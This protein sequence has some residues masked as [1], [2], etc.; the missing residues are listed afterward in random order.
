MPTTG[1]RCARR[2]G[3]HAGSG[4]RR[5]RAGRC[6][7]WEATGVRGWGRGAAYRFGR[8]AD[9]ARVSTVPSS[10]SVPQATAA[11]LAALEEDVVEEEAPEDSEDEEFLLGG[12]DEDEDEPG[13][14]ATSRRERDEAR[15]RK[16]RAAR[17][18]ESA[19]PFGDWLYEAMEAEEPVAGGWV[20]DTSA[21]PATVEE[22]AADASLSARGGRGRGRGSGRASDGGA[23]GA[24]GASS[25]SGG[26]SGGIADRS[27]AAHDAQRLGSPPGGMLQS[28]APGGLPPLPTSGRTRR[29]RRAEGSLR[30]LS[31][32]ELDEML[33]SGGSGLAGRKRGGGA[34]RERAAAAAAAPPPPCRCA[35]YLSSRAPPQRTRAPHRACSVCGG[36]GRYACPRCGSRSCSVRCTNIHLETWCL[37]MIA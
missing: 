30:E 22:P 16:S 34:A 27:G 10:R 13:G 8:K 21:G 26:A 23:R 28:P 33:E 29:A 19:R 1:R 3:D 9:G 25:G 32:S 14:R 24:F 6:Q 35:S 2:S 36:A 12:S 17:E 15:A 20:G 7:G 18:R 11:R 31:D 4:R 5:E 37:K